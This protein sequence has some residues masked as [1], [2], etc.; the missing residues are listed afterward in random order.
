MSFKRSIHFIWLTFSLFFSAAQVNSQITYE[1]G[2]FI[3]NAGNRTECL[4]RNV[5]WM[6]NPDSFQY[7]FSESGEVQ[8]GNLA[9][10]QEFGV[11]G[12][13]KYVKSTVNIDRSRQE[14]DKLTLVREPSFTNETLFLLVLV[15]GK[16]K[17]YKYE[18]AYGAKYFYQV[19]DGEIKPM[20]YRKYITRDNRIGENLQYKQQLFNAFNGQGVTQKELSRLS[21]NESSLTNFFK[22][23]N[24]VNNI[25][26][27]SVSKNSKKWI[28]VI[29]RPGIHYSSVKLTILPTNTATIGREYTF[30]KEL[31]PRIGVEIE[32]IMPFNKNKWA[33]TAEPFYETYKSELP[34]S[35][36]QTLSVDYKYFGLG[37]GIRHYLFLNNNS[38]LFINASGI[39]AL[40]GGNSNIN[41]GAIREIEKGSTAAAGL[42]F[43]YKNKLFVEIRHT[44]DRQLLKYIFQNAHYSGQSL[45]L[46]YRL[47]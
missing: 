38:K 12:V 29:L 9:N 39:F 27:L 43:A 6:K 44:F 24:N 5:D 31:S 23:V 47:F 21:Y 15:E 11:T 2:Y 19:S 32:A 36:N 17:L 45:I 30:D 42:G 33:I 20:V 10:M 25:D 41:I 1:E 13:S 34:I 8:N 40:D 7:K 28:N 16:A 4:I 22:K 26:V 3:D 46:G 35:T 18:D 14:V 37:F